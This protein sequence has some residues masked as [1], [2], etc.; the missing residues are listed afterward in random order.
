MARRS[1]PCVVGRRRYGRL[2]IANADAG[3]FAYT[4]SAIDQAWR[5]VGELLG[6]TA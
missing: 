3:A 6:G 5:A 4:N 1:E 2:T